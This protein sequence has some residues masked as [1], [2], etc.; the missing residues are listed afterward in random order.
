VV[1]KD[2]RIAVHGGVTEIR[3]QRSYLAKLL[4]QMDVSG[5]QKNPVKQK[6]AMAR[7]AQHNAAK[8]AMYDEGA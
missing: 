7:W 1:L 2:G 5:T 8:A 6:A 4:A 3:L